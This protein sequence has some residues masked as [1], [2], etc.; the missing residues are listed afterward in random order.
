MDNNN[1]DKELNKVIQLSKLS[2]IQEKAVLIFK[3][4]SKANSKGMKLLALDKFTKLGY[5][6]EDFKNAIEFIKNRSQIVIH[7]KLDV[8][9][10]FL[11]NDTHYRNQF[12]TKTSSGALSELSRKDWEKNLFGNVYDSAA[13]FERVKYG[14]INITNDPKGVQCAYGYGNCYFVL[15]DSVKERTS[16]VHGDS[17]SKE[18]HMCSFDDYTQIL[19]Y[20]DDHLLNEVVKIA[21]N[22][23]PHS[24]YV[25]SPYIEMQIHGPVELNSDI[26]KLVIHDSYKNP[27][28]NIFLKSICEFCHKNNIG[29]EFM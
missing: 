12:E 26:E 8:I 29:Y 17:A 27:I 11:I 6:K 28:N 21:N 16:F 13:A 14:A 20:I 5:S 25:Y 18:M 10:Q 24:N 19:Y 3:R 7:V 23:I 22:K 9:H 2:K 1:N 15:K 4:K